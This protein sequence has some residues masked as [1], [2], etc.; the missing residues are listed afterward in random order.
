MTVLGVAYKGNVDNTR[1]S[2]AVE[3]I[4][5]LLD[6]GVEVRVYYP[7]VGHFD[8]ELWNLEAAF[9]GSDLALM[10]DHNE[11]KYLSADGLGELMSNKIV[12]D[13]KIVSMAV[14]GKKKD[15][16]WKCWVDTEIRGALDETIP[17]DDKKNGSRMGTFS[18]AV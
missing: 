1:E 14:S 9:Q 12:F 16:E 10:A 18:H 11:F 3:V 2:P 7:H 13:T 15:L 17:A 4:E 5:E 6:S 8:H